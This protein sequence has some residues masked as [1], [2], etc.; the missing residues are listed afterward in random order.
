LATAIEQAAEG[1]IITDTESVILYVNPAFER[2]SGYG[3]S[4]IVGQHSHVLKTEDSDQPFFTDIPGTL[5]QGEMRPGHMTNKR[6]D[7]SLYEVEVTISPVRDDSGNIMNYVGLH[8]DIT[9]EVKLERE[10]RQAQKM[11]AIGRLAGGIAH[12]FNNVLMG[13]IGYT[14]MALNKA[15][16]GDSTRHYLQRV[17]EGSYRASDLVKQILTFSRQTE[18]EL[19]PMYIVPSIKEGLKLLRSTL[20]SSIEIQQHIAVTSEEGVI[21]AD[22][23]QIHQV[24]MNLCTNAAHAMRNKGGVLSIKLSTVEADDQLVSQH[25]DLI[26]GPYVCLTVSD[27]G[28]GMDAAV[29]ERIFDPYFTTKKIGEG[30]GMGLAVVQGIIKSCGGA[31]SVSS[32]PGNGTSFYVFLPRIEQEMPSA[33]EAIPAPLGGSER[34]LFVDDEETLV[35]LGKEA[36]ES[37]GYQ[38]SAKMTSLEALETFRAQPEGFDL[39]IT[40]M[41]MPGLTGKELAKELLALRPDIPIILCTGFSEIV[42]EN[43]AKEA[44]IREFVMKPYV[45][46]N[47]ANIVRKV[48]K[49][50]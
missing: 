20:P 15:P 6:K 3:R 29:M 50:T 13:I 25:P 24:L 30:T 32:E 46:S 42:D 45:V 34:I 5:H 2:I 35:D 19:K 36:L 7:G 9:H 26:V 43:Q 38:V 12:D 48:L 28:H 27:T 47:L 22:P 40:D 49:Q 11:E 14:E 33:V 18:Q 10:L 41:T 16:A 17:L 44:G 39:V 37:L 4:E 21:L 1:I 8:R 31:I 23:T